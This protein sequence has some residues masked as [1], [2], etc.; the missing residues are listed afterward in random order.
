MN[1]KQQLFIDTAISLFPDVATANQ[2]TRSQ[3]LVV[4][5]KLN[6]KSSPK[7]LMENKIHWTVFVVMGLLIAAA[8]TSIHFYR[9]KV[10]EKL[11]VKYESLDVGAVLAKKLSPKTPQQ[12][13]IT[14]RGF[15]HYYLKCLNTGE[16]VLVSKSRVREDFDITN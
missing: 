2:I 4:R 13:V 5:K 15:N 14:N 11:L 16:Q 7:W 3:V 10:S 9:A 12:F 1:T 6:L 8:A